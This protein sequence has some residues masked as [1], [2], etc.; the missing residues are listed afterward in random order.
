MGWAVN[1]GGYSGKVKGLALNF[2]EEQK[3]CGVLIKG[4]LRGI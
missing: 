2:V 1:R 3:A 4:R